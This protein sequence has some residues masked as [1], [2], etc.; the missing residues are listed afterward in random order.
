MRPSRIMCWAPGCAWGGQID[1]SNFGSR[2]APCSLPAYRRAPHRCVTERDGCG[3]IVG[4]PE[5]E[6]EQVP[7]EVERGELTAAEVGVVWTARGDRMEDVL[8][9]ELGEELVDVGDDDPAARRAGD[10]GLG[11]RAHGALAEIGTAPA[12][13]ARLPQVQHRVA[14]CKDGE[15]AVVVEHVE[16]E[17]VVVE[18]H[19]G[20]GIA[21]GKG[22]NGLAQRYVGPSPALVLRGH[23][24]RRS[25]L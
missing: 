11:A 21:D 1:A 9:G 7:V 24:H 17:A 15:A 4:P 18:G 10:E 13:V 5:E 8:R 16:A 19:R 20:L 12:L 3:S 22:G 23:S 25:S 2:P 14:A 6:R